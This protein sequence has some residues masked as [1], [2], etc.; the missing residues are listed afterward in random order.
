M[1]TQSEHIG[2]GVYISFDGFQYWLA[3]NDPAN[4]Q[5]ALEP[6]TFH[7]LVDRMSE[8]PAFVDAIMNK[9]REIKDANSNG[10]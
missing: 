8:H 6:I 2:D 4:A 3:A 5:V 1:R 9:V 7:G 10:L